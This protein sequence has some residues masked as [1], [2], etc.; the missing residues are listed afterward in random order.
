[1]VYYLKYDV[2]AICKRIVNEQMSKS[3]LKYSL[4]NTHELAFD[5]IITEE[6]LEL[7]NR[8]F[9]KL[10][11]EIVS[12]KKSMLVQKIKEAIIGFVNLE[13]KI[14]LS[15]TSS[16][17]S[18]TL[19]YSYRYLS[20]IFSEV[21]YTTIENYI[22]LQKIERAKGMIAGGEFS[23]T[24]IAWKLN[25]SSVAHF[26]TQFKNTTGLTPSS[27]KRIINQRRRNMLENIIS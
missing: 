23:F 18:D 22:I 1:M 2:Q 9:N 13:D 10:G 4:L 20:A 21:T 3:G 26:S 8:G 12:S 19:N 7:L 14:V 11:I 15:K 6:S 24:E 16:Y 27:F 17:L 25:Y 5:Q